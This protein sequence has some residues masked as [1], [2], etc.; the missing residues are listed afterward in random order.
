MG[1][2]YGFER[3]DIEALRPSSLSDEVARATSRGVETIVSVVGFCRPIP[4]GFRGSITTFDHYFRS[5]L[6][7]SRDLTE[8]ITSPTGQQPFGVLGAAVERAAEQ[9]LKGPGWNI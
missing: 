4:T 1:Y 3:I 5:L 8:L 7:E 2:G 6:R 9:T